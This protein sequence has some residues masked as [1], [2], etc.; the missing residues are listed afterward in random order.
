MWM[1][2]EEDEDGDE[3]LKG[4]PTLAFTDQESGWVGAWAEPRKGHHW[5]AVK[6]LTRQIKG[7]GCKRIICRSYHET[8][9]KVIKGMAKME[10]MCK[11]VYEESPVGESNLW[12]ASMCRCSPSRE[13]SAHSGMLWNRGMGKGWNQPA[14]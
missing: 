4:M 9:I 5:Y 13:W 14:H 7:L 3:S 8:A 12:E 11:L 6:A 2:S 1:T 10:S